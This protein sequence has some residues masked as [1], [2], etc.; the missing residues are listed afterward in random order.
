MVSAAQ[1]N[2]IEAAL[3]PARIGTEISTSV[4]AKT[5]DAAREQGAQLVSLIDNAGQIAPG[6]ALVAKATGMGSLLDVTA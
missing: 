6:D 4:A 3:T 2:L 5:L 1:N